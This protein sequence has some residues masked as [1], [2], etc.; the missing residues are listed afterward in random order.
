MENIHK[1]DRAFDIFVDLMV[2]MIELYGTEV[3]K[4]LDAAENNCNDADIR[5]RL[6][7]N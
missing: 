2:G 4:E 3:L 6:E 7:W 1:M 5:K